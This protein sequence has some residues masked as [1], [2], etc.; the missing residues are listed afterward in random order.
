MRELIF[1]DTETTGLNAETDE[2]VELTWATL[3]SEPKTVYFGV[4][5]V[6]E[7]IDDLIKFTERGISGKESTVEEVSEFLNSS[8]DN[9]M[10]AANPGF[11]QAFLANNGLWQFHYR[12]LD[13]E[14]Y[15]MCAL[16]LPEMPGMKMV[17]DELTGMGFHI[18]EPDHTSR[19][20]VLAMRDA[21]SI[22]KRLPR[23]NR[24]YTP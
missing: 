6:P 21:W 11:D 7:F 8:N 18:T 23:K 19:N 14:S 24:V 5:E 20:D 10:V 4:E 13:L 22:L 1:V 2:L 16:D 9:T 17:Y 3:T 12:M 15:A